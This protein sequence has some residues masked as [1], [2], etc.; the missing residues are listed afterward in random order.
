VVPLDTLDCQVSNLNDPDHSGTAYRWDIARRPD[1]STTEFDAANDPESSVFV[2]IAGDY[3]L[4]VTAADESTGTLC[5]AMVQ[6][7]ATYGQDVS[8]QVTWD[9]PGDEDQ[10]DEGLSSGTDLD[11]HYLNRSLGCWTQT[12]ADCHWRNKTPDWPEYGN[13]NDDPSIDI[14]DVNGAGPEGAS[15]DNPGAGAY[16]VGVNYYDSHG[17]GNSIATLNL[18][19]FGVVV[20]SETRELTE[21]QFWH[22]ADISWPEGN[23][24]LVNEIYENISNARCTAP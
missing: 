21:G 1:G 22:V 8:I 14:D 19:V 16:S 7:L 20:L 17:F 24:R 5:Q 6:V 18:Y 10:T 15:H 12:P 3:L 2:D 9:T 13:R 11:L 23:V 4:E